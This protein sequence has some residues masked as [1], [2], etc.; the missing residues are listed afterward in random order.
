MKKLTLFTTALLFAAVL[1]A[2]ADLAGETSDNFLATIEA[3]VLEAREGVKSVAFSPNG[4]MLATAGRLDG[5]VKV[6]DAKTLQII[7]I[8]DGAP[9]PAAYVVFSPGSE[10]L[11]CGA[12]RETNLWHIATQMQI[13][14]LADV[15]PMA[16]SQDG[17]MLATA[18]LR[19]RVVLWDMKTVQSISAL[20]LSGHEPFPRSIA[21]SPDDRILATTVGEEIKLWDLQ[22]EQPVA[23]LAG[24][25]TPVHT[26]AYS[27]D[28]TILVSGSYPDHEHEDQSLRLWDVKSGQVVG[29]IPVG[30]TYSL[31]LSLDGTILAVAEDSG[32]IGL[33]D[34]E[35]RQ[36][37]ATLRG[38][39]E[40]VRQFA[41]SPD[42]T[43]LASA[44]FSS[45]NVL[46]WD[47][48]EFVAPVAAIPDANLRAVIREA[49]G[50][51]PLFA[52]ITVPD[53]ERL[54]ALD[55]SSRN[56]RELGGLELATGLTDLNLQGNPL[57]SSAIATLIP[58]LQEKGVRV[59]FDDVPGIS[60]LT[61]L[62][63]DG[64][65]S[66]PGARLPDPLAVSVLDPNGNGVAGVMVWFSVAGGGTLS[67][68]TATTDTDGRAAATLTLG[69][70][71]SATTIVTAA[72][73]GLE[74]VT[75][76]AST[77]GVPALSAEQINV[78]S[79]S[80]SP[81]GRTLASFTLSKTIHLWEVAGGREIQK[82][83]TL[84]GTDQVFCVSFSPDGRTLA[85]GSWGTVRLWD[86]VRGQEKAVLEGHS[87]D[88]IVETLSFSPD[89]RILASAGD[90]GTVRLWD[91]VRGQEKA[92]LE[93]HIGTVEGVSF[94]PDN[95][96]LASGG[97][98]TVR[99]WDVASGG[100]YAVR[101]W[102]LASGQREAT[103][104]LYKY[105]VGLLSFSP[106]GR[107]LVLRLGDGTVRLWDTVSGAQTA[108]IEHSSFVHSVSFSPNGQ[109]LALGG[110]D[111]TILLWNVVRGQAITVLAGHR[112]FV[113]S[114]SF[115]PDGRTLVS[116][117]GILILLWDDMPY[118]TATLTRVSGDGQQGAPGD[119]LADP[120]AVSVRDEDGS[121]IAGAAVRFSVTSG[122]GTLSATTVTT[123]TDGRAVATLTLGSEPGTNTVVA[124]VSGLGEVTFSATAEATA[125]VSTDFNDDKV[126]DFDDFFLFAEAFGSSDPRFDLDESG[127][128][129]F[130]DF[131]LFAEQ[132]G[133]PARAKLVALAGELIG[134][135]KGPQLR[136]NAPNPFNS[137][138]VISWFQVQ[139]G[140]A[141]LEVFA[142]T[143]QRVAVL[144]EGPRKA[145]LHRLRWDG[146]GDQGRPLASGVYLYRLVMNEGAQTRKLILLR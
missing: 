136:Q 135:P 81:D 20:P 104:E 138:T 34:V 142:L 94:S 77:S 146:R 96:T 18:S 114:V 134:L 21:F 90:D 75:F 140:P 7:A 98:Y 12:A 121:G 48:S 41:F 4:A 45:G 22:T 141:R 78:Q 49:L 129:D 97:D 112:D 127:S 68:T 10:I 53:M 3:H 74:A 132:F 118:V 57:I 37:T 59:L 109:T 106:D 86:V 119:Q 101:L 51:Q 144:H 137:E 63:G 107:T 128:V 72:V 82:I 70:L 66:A 131:F 145:G 88:G 93:G 91:V 43:T 35:T 5:K 133:Q 102:D 143:G 79:V 36:K 115:S 65:Q 80:F 39:I 52:P 1:S 105:T 95:R 116:S 73:A 130:N 9:G 40:A 16:F 117:D 62:S 99:L 29:S 50:K 108:V 32:R 44:D 100:D 64:Q 120:L 15:V 61:K 60:T 13:G 24:H 17:A 14:T 124:T 33:W 71:P 110:D 8:L 76:T 38:Q 113:N 139:P 122:G 125:E 2:P 6:W 92:V 111:G 25:E 67:A 46:L 58:A 85:S 56:I 123:D 126:T 26:V 31:A 55:A 47:M 69:G 42:G 54:T 27:P 23:T 19:R 84:E 89:G 28:G 87:A 11:A 30:S 103:L 83:A